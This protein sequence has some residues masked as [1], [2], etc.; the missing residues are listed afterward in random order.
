MT[1]TH[2]RKAVVA[3]VDGSASSVAA[4]LFGLE[5]ARRRRLP[6]RLVHVVDEVPAAPPGVLDA[7]LDAARRS[8]PDLEVSTEVPAGRAA[9]ALLVAAHD[10]D[11]LVVGARGA[12]GFR[13]LLLGSVS[14]QVAAHASCPVVV[15]RAQRRHQ[16]PAAGVIVGVDG[17]STSDAAVEFAFEEAALHGFG[18]TAVHVFGPGEV[19][20]EAVAAEPR[21]LAAEEARVLTDSLVGW[22]Q[23]YPDVAVTARLVRGH[24]AATLAGESVDGQLLVVGT[25]GRG[26]FG[27]LLLGSVSQSVLLHAACPVAVVPRRP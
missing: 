6:L 9:A 22:Q 17:S 25:R 5:E 8:A 15:V 19:S 14:S 21:R 27:G 24:A 7:A 1:L 12:G 20:H 23:K 26:G 10:A 13:G 16:P 18:V 3:G 2:G 11:V 4:V